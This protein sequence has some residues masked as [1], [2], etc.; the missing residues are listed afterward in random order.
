[1]S[2]KFLPQINAFLLLVSFPCFN[3]T[4]VAIVDDDSSDVWVCH[5]C[6]AAAECGGRKA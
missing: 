2:D 1:M 6:D 4:K 3:V 5:M